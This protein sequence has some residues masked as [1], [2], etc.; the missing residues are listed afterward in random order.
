MSVTGKRAEH[1][2]IIQNRTNI[3]EMVDQMKKK[4]KEERNET[5]GWELHVIYILKFISFK[6]TGFRLNY[7]HHLYILASK[8]VTTLSVAIFTKCETQYP[9]SV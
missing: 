9:I 1:S 7:K 3:I 5:P 2:L 6:T 4:K 8:C